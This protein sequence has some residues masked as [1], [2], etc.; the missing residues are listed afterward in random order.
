MSCILRVSSPP[1]KRKNIFIEEV[2]LTLAATL[3]SIAVDGFSKVT[4]LAI[5]E[6]AEQNVKAQLN[7]G[8]ALN[9]KMMQKFQEIITKKDGINQELSNVMATLIPKLKGMKEGDP[10]NAF[11]EKLTSSVEASRTNNEKLVEAFASF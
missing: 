9:P 4:G 7:A 8:E 1:D 6:L 3:T 2:D 10:L 5:L 11:V